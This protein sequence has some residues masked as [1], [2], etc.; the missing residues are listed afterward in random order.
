MCIFCEKALRELSGGLTAAQKREAEG[1][2]TLQDRQVR[3]TIL[4]GFLGAG[5]TTFLNFVLKS[6]GHGQRIAVVQNEFGSVS[7]DDQL[8]L[9]ERSAAEVVVMP[10]GCLCCRVRGDLVDALK[11]LAE[12]PETFAAAG[13]SSE[14]RLPIDSLVIEC[15][16]LSEVLPVAQ[17]FFA[18]PYVQASFKLDSVVCVCDASNFED[19]EGGGQELAGTAGPEVSRLLREQ[20]ALSDVCILNKCDLVDSSKRDRV[21]QRARA[22][23]PAIKVVPCR[24]GK[25]NLGQVMKINSFSLDAV[26]SLDAHFLTGGDSVEIDGHGHGHGH[27]DGGHSGHGGSEDTQ[28]PAH[29]HDSMSSLGLEMQDGVDRTALEAW[30]RTVVERMG[31]G[32]IRLKGVLR[33]QSNEDLRL[34]VQGVGGHIEIGEAGSEKFTS[35]TSRLVIIGQVADFQLRKKLKEGFLALAAAAAPASV[36]GGAK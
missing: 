1:C 33:C 20:L 8:M 35:E 34:I 23:N 13:S 2:A 16:G 17:T 9:L 30:L 29:A 18:D 25:V 28:T 12:R 7:I 14:G 10:N 22:L 15:S 24:Q 11:R 21:S 4:T 5:K 32:L 19:L 6:L 3:V 31:N 36:T 27:N 26:L